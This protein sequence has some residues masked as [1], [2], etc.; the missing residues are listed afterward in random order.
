MATREVLVVIESS[1]SVVRQVGQIAAMAVRCE[2]RVTGLFATGYPVATAYGDVNSWMPLVEAYL[3][4]QRN[5]A[6]AAEAAFRQELA[7]HKLAGDWIYQESD[8]TDSVT[9]LGALFDLVVI[10][11]PNPDA[12]SPTVL[13]LR[14]AVAVMA[15]GRPVLMVPYAGDFPEFG[16]R[17]LVA[18]NGSREAARALHDSMFLLEQAEAVTIIEVD[19]L[20]PAAGMVRVSAAD[21]AAALVRRGVAATAES[22]TSDGISVDDL[23]LSRAADLGVDL[24]VMGAYGHSR[25]R[26]YVLGGVSRGVF[27]HMTVPVL[28]AH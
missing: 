10:A 18:W 4:A 1:T 27:Q 8:G 21:V 23:L 12:E 6:G 2:A 19:A 28:M 14:P 17:V 3:E 11:Q 24:L 13:A 26:E 15:T 16:K 9:T 20:A 22:Q 7:Q 5:E 25:L